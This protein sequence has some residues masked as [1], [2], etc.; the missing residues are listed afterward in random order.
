MWFYVLNIM[1]KNFLKLFSSFIDLSNR[2]FIFSRNMSVGN[3]H[4]SG[5]HS[6]IHLNSFEIYSVFSECANL[7]QQSHAVFFFWSMLI[8]LKF[9]KFSGICQFNAISV[10]RD[11]PIV[12]F[13]GIFQWFIHGLSYFNAFF[14]REK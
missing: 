10:F 12:R 4:A 13:S 3:F 6:Q 2:K 9:I 1:L 14:L 11:I 5:Y 8:Y 7:S